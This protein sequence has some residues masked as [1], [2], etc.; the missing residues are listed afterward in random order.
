MTTHFAV[1]SPKYASSP[2][3]VLQPPLQWYQARQKGRVVWQVGPFCGHQATRQDR[4]RFQRDHHGQLEPRLEAHRGGCGSCWLAPSLDRLWSTNA[5]QGGMAAP[6]T[7]SVSD[8]D[9]DG[10]HDL[11]G[12]FTCSIQELVSQL[13]NHWQLLDARG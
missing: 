2:N 12:A 3:L 11:I 5:V 13:N 4:F 8:Y 9:V 1:G 6:V 7:I 10:N